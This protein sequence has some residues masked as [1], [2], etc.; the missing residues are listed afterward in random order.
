MGMFEG[1]K[2]LILG[3]ANDHSIAWYIAKA[4]MAEGADLGFTHI[5]DSDER[6]RMEGRVRK[7]AEPVGAKL[8]TPCDVQKDEDIARVFKEAK[9]T[10]GELDF[11]VH[12]VAYAP[13]DDIRKPYLESSR[14]GFITAMDVSVYS[15]VAVARA[16]KE[17]LTP[18]GSLLTLTYYGGEKAVPGYN[19]MG[20]A[21][22][23]LDAS[24]RYLAFDLGQ[25]GFRMNAISAGPIRTLSASAVGDFKK[26][27]KIYEDTAP[28]RR[29][30]TAEEVGK[31]AAYLLSDMAS[32]VTGEILHVD[33]GYNV[34]GGPA[35]APKETPQ[36]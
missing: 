11:V 17:V 32:G 20:V 30:V 23:A 9:D 13:M 35:P 16:A 12:S 36:S 4:L 1:K 24:V 19:L 14:A 21:K 6:K 3:V 22:A 10:Y 5:P 28:L 29:N 2:G 33:G 7:L 8:I 34:M 26:I 18:G 31:T 15:L 25:D 27:F